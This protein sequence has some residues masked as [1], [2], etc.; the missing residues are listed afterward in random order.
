M[1]V[2]LARQVRFSPVFRTP[3]MPQFN[4][5]I[6]ARY[7]GIG[8]LV[9]DAT[10]TTATISFG[11]GSIGELYGSH[12][13]WDIQWLNC[14]YD[15]GVGAAVNLTFEIRTFEADGVTGFR[16]SWGGSIS[17]GT[18]GH[19]FQTIPP[20]MKYRTSDFVGSPSVINFIGTNENTN[21]FQAAVSGFIYDERMI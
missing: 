18:F 17:L 21:V 14:C 1:S 4:P 15:N 12:A 3:G 20:V 9:C 2:S 10:G 7:L 8:R 6:I 19:N 11:L 13:L 5:S 16:G